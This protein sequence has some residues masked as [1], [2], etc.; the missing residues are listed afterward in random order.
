MASHPPAAKGVWRRH[1]DWAV[2]IAGQLLVIALLFL[3]NWLKHDE[4]RARP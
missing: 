3:V 1:S 2:G 4:L